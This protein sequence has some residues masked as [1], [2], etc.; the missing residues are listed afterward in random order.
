M[1]ILTKLDVKHK[2]QLYLACLNYDFGTKLLVCLII[3]AY[4][5]KHERVRYMSIGSF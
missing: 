2:V 1:E 3:V 5:E 4:A